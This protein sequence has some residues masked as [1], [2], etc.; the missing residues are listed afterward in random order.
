MAFAVVALVGCCAAP[1]R[2]DTL[3]LI[4]GL[5]ATYTPGEQFTFQLRAPEL[6]GLIGYHL[7]MTFATDVGPAALLAFPTF[8]TDGTYPFGTANASFSFN[9]P[10]ATLTVSDPPDPS[11]PRDPADVTPGFNDLLATITVAP[12][13]GLTGTLT[14]SFT[15]NTIFTL[16][17]GDNVQGFGSVQVQQ[18]EPPSGNPVPAPP[19]VVLFGV[20]ALLV[21]ARARLRGK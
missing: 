3:P 6:I 8:P 19:G 5:P 11:P 1:A 10:L 16:Q 13:A 15:S 14:I 17:E 21:C 7:E 20:G 18:G 9:T 2:A 4:E 12:D